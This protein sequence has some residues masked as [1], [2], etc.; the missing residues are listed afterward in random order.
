VLAEI[1]VHLPA[2]AVLAAMASSSA[3]SLTGFSEI[4]HGTCAQRPLTGL[5][6]VEAGDDDDRE[7]HFG[8]GQPVQHIE[9]VTIGM[10]ISSTTQS[11]L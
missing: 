8:S 10:L 9:P 6:R 2:G 5:G 11:G 1:L 4:G 7:R 3:W